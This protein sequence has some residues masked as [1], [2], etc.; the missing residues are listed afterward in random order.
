M[1]PRRQVPYYYDLVNAVWGGL[2]LGILYTC[3]LLVVIDYTADRYALRAAQEA[4]R[5]QLTWVR[6]QRSS[7]DPNIVIACLM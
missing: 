2:W 1:L 5:S 3:V 7:F 6:R 4:Y